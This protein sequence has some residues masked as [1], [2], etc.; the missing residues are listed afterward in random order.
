MAEGYPGLITIFFRPDLETPT[1]L[2][3]TKNQIEMATANVFLKSSKLNKAGEAP[4]KI[5]VYNNG[6]KREKS[7]GLRVRSDQ[8]DAEKR[9]V[10]RN[11]PQSTRLN[12]L[13]A[14]ERSKYL[15]LAVELESGEKTLTTGSIDHLVSR[16]GNM[17]LI[18]LME[19]K[20]RDFARLEKVSSSLH[21]SQ[22]A[23][24]L[25]WFMEFLG[26]SV[27]SVSDLKREIKYPGTGEKKMV[28]DAYIKFLREERGNAPGTIRIYT[29]PLRLVLNEKIKKGLLDPVHKPYFELPKCKPRLDFLTPEQL[30][31]LIELPIKEGIKADLARDMYLLSALGGGLRYVDVAALQW[32]HVEEGKRLNTLTRKTGSRVQMNLGQVPLKILAKYRKADSLPTDFIFPVLPPDFLSRDA[33]KRKHLIR[34]SNSRLNFHLKVM[35]RKIGVKHTMSF[36]TARHTFATVAVSKG[37]K[38]TVLKN[39]LGHSSITQT[40]KYWHL[41]GK[42]MDEE[43]EKFNQQVGEWGGETRNVTSP[44]PSPSKAEVIAPK[45]PASS[46]PQ[47]PQVEMLRFYVLQTAR[48]Q[49]SDLSPHFEGLVVNPNDLETYGRELGLPESMCQTVLIRTFAYSSTVPGEKAGLALEALQSTLNANSLFPGVRFAVAPA[50]REMVAQWADGRIEWKD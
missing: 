10:K 22:T 6:K 31:A 16:G 41:L 39:L 8:W 18:E 12:K 23:R 9:R 26:I 47:S 45:T 15:E 1:C 30:K 43:V 13:I 3:F 50:L 4:V 35:A 40:E 17:N 11:H 27:L 38:V 37:M 24:R 33:F 25:E 19:E 48:M 14:R 28:L 5:L 34:K 2:R 46:I 49:T 7:L 20:A 29:K 42:D 21:C 32:C 44:G 36:H